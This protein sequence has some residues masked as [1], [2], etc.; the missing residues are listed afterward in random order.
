MMTCFFS[1][2]LIHG[3]SATSNKLKNYLIVVFFNRLWQYCFINWGGKL[4]RK[5]KIFY[6]LDFK[7]WDFE[8]NNS[9]NDQS[10]DA[11]DVFNGAKVG[12]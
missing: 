4:L 1:Q 7:P 10:S 8:K 12:L 2:T 11:K 6:E 5:H 3:L 9:I